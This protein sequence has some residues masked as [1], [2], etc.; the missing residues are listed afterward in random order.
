MDVSGQL[1]VFSLGRDVTGMDSTG[2][3]IY[4]DQIGFASFEICAP[5]GA[6]VSLKLKIFQ[7]I[8][9]QRPSGADMIG[10]LARVARKS[11][12][13]RSSLR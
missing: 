5:S 10:E 9:L 6:F 1:S 3:G 2:Q 4:M 13:K 11:L 8:E 7:E 12:V